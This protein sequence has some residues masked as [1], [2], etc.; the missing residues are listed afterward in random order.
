MGLGARCVLRAERRGLGAWMVPV[1]GGSRG[2]GLSWS[3]EA[4]W[5]VMT[6]A[7]GVGA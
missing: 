7:E 6:W 5:V 1:H 4:A 3:C 2:L